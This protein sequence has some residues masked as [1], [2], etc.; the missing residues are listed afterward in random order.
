MRGKRWG[1]EFKH[2]AL[3]TKK[4]KENVHKGD[5]ICRHS[6]L[7]L[8]TNVYLHYSTLLIAYAHPS[9]RNSAEGIIHRSNC[10]PSDVAKLPVAGQMLSNTEAHGKVGRDGK[11]LWRHR[12]RDVVERAACRWGPWLQGVAFGHLQSWNSEDISDLAYQLL[13]A[14][15]VMPLEIKGANNQ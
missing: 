12:M 3:P 4:G 14:N 11:L 13:L 10:F 15:R 2:Y 8:S 7:C 6:C 9:H 1:Q 5:T